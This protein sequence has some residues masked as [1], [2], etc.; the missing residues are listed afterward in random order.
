VPLRVDQHARA[1]ALLGLRQAR[2]EEVLE[3]AVEERIARERPE[4]D[5]IRLL[6]W[7]PEL[8]RAQGEAILAVD[9]ASV[10]EAR[11]LLAEAAEL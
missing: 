8:V 6:K 4:L 11:S 1:E 10:E 5:R 3:E 9:P 2:L 7:I